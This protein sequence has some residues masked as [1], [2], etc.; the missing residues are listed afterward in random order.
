[1]NRLLRIVR[2][3]PVAGWPDGLVGFRQDTVGLIRRRWLLLTL[4]A[5]AGNLAV[6][7]VSARLAARGRG[8]LRAR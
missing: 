3:G 1:M 6:F 8:E 5:V 7:L 4:A 2:R